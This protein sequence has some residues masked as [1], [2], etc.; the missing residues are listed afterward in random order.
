MATGPGTDFSLKLKDGFYFSSDSDLNFPILQGNPVKG[1]DG[2]PERE[3]A[4]HPTTLT[5]D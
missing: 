2:A 4:E 5:G 1:E 3:H